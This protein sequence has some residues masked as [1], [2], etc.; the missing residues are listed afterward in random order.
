MLAGSDG[1]LEG[2]IVGQ[3]VVVWRQFATFRARVDRAAQNPAELTAAQRRYLL[4]KCKRLVTTKGMMYLAGPAAER[5]KVMGPPPGGGDPDELELYR[6]GLEMDPQ[7]S[8]VDLLT[9]L[10][11]AECLFQERSTR[12]AYVGDLYDRT[13]AL[14]CHPCVWAATERLAGE[15]L[16]SGEVDGGTARRLCQEAELLPEV[17][18]ARA[19]L[20]RCPFADRPATEVFVA[21]AE[22][23]AKQYALGQLYPPEQAA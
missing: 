22:L 1:P 5:R 13:L 11:H 19:A 3:C 8:V 15:L 4:A 16:H 18:D 14:V 20:G 12:H 21:L 17:K 6:D 10:Q 23:F 9:T 7:G 2:R